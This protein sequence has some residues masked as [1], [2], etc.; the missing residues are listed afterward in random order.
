MIIKEC[1]TDTVTYLKN[2]KDKAVQISRG[3][4][5]IPARRNSEFFPKRGQGG[6][7]GDKGNVSYRG[8]W[9]SVKI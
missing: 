5:N 4:T 7:L 8:L 6:V 9:A 3:R 2:V 1:C